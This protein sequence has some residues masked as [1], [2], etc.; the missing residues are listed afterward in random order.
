MG[1]AKGT[2]TP[3]KSGEIPG[4]QRK[5]TGV[6]TRTYDK[7]PGETR[8][9]VEE[10]NTASDRIHTAMTCPASKLTD[11]ATTTGTMSEPP[12]SDDNTAVSETAAAPP[13]SNDPGGSMLAWSDDDA[14]EV[15]RAPWRVAYWRAAAVLAACIVVAAAVAG[16][17]WLLHPPAHQHK[18]DQPRG[19]A[20]SVSS[21]PGPLN[22]LYRVDRYRGQS[23][24]HKPD[25]GLQ[26]AGGATA[27]VETEWWA[28]LSSCVQGLCTATG[29]MLDNDTHQHPA[30]NNSHLVS[31]EL[32]QTLRLVN[33]QWVSARPNSAQQPCVEPAGRADTWQWSLT[34]TPLADGN[35]KGEEADRVVT[36]ECSAMGTVI[37]TPVAATRIGDVPPVIGVTK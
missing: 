17:F 19:A 3:L 27:T 26:K 33:G 5:D 36:D 15:Q 24:I 2:R 23:V 34:L 13:I 32:T 16:A 6:I 12:A 9:C 30:V 7:S 4:E 29:T 10:I 18:A 25:G 37:N 31:D 1:G 8:R 35:L 22:G 11:R 20:P 28:Y 14:N 21:T